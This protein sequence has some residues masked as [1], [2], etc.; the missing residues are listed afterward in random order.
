MK[1]NT[2]YGLIFLLVLGFTAC[3]NVEKANNENEHE[4][5]TTVSLVFKINDAVV[6]TFLFD[7]P[8][9]DGGNLPVRIDT[10]LLNSNSSYSVEAI[11]TNK[12]KNPPSDVTQTIR[13][14]G[15]SHEFFFLPNFSGLAIQKTDVDQ[16]GLPL[17]LSSVWTTNNE[18]SFGSVQIKLMHKPIVKGPNDGPNVGHSDIDIT[19]PIKIQ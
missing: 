16:L 9:G 13:R 6:D 1:R 12:T 5:V 2:L 7:D 11:L 3:N 10:I 4:A 15:S 18:L 8:D 14:Q 19:M 17:G